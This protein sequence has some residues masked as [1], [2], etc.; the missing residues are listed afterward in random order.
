MRQVTH[1]AYNASL[2]TLLGYHLARTG[3][4][5]ATRQQCGVLIS[6]SLQCE[7][8]TFSLRPYCSGDRLLSAFQTPGLPS[9]GPELR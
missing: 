8:C 6:L 9:L 7:E 4:H 5:P 3:R 1:I 2:H